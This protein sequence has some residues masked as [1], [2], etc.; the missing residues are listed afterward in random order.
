GSLKTENARLESAVTGMAIDHL[1]AQA[2]FS[3][4]Q[5]IFSQISGQTT[6]GGTVS[7]SGTVTFTNGRTA[8]NMSFNANQALLLNRDDIAGRVHGP[9]QVKSDGRTGTISGNFRLNKGLFQLGRASAAAAVP[10][11]V[12]RDRGLDAEDVIEAADLHP[13]KLDMRVAGSELR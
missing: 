8:L 10:Q 13:W 5:L 1:A 2:R 9:L 6:G 4:P 3:G 7:G 11:L 12:V